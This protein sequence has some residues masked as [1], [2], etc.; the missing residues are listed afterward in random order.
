MGRAQEPIGSG[1]GKR[2]TAGDVLDGID[3]T[4]RLAVITGGYS[5][6][7]LEITRAL[8]AAGARVIV[9]ARRPD[10]AHEAL[11]AIGGTEVLAM[12]LADLAS[13]STA[14][15]GLLVR[16]EPIDMLIANA[17]IM[18]CPETRVGPGWEAQFATNHLGHFAL[19][20]RLWPMLTARGSRV[21]TVSSGAH[22]ITGIRWHDVHF[23]TEYDPWQ[24]YGQSK[25]ANVLMAVELDKRGAA[26]GVRAFSLDPGSILTPLQRH[27]SREWMVEQGWMDA[28]G[29]G[30]N[31][32]FKTPEQG[33]ATATWAATS[34]QLEGAG[35]V[36]CVDCD[37]APREGVAAWAIDAAEAAR[38]WELS[39]ELTGVDIG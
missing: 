7:G 1:F 19:T 27:L 16:G 36:F 14:A 22:R 5:G 9:P 4:G 28:D 39:T 8:S 29:R 11:A 2:S 17:G 32:D 23:E 21:V 25:T 26:H 20:A 18:A 34:P 12:D 13:V 33:A 30:I 35:G 10:A 38:L 6:L 37:V 15:D 24:A 31:P 3:L